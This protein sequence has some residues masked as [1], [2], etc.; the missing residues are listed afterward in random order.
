MA[1]NR[2]H[3]F[4]AGG[5][6]CPAPMTRA[7]L[8]TLRSTN[9]LKPE[10]HY[11]ITDHV[12]NRLVAGTT[13]TMH[14]VAP[15]ELSE[16]VEVNTTYDNEAWSGIYD[17]D[18]ALVLELTDNRNNT[19][20]GVNGTEV[21]NFDWG[22]A[23][24]SGCLVDNATWTV[25]YGSGGSVQR[26]RITNGSTLVTTGFVGSLLEPVITNAAVVNLTNA[27]GSWRYIEWRNS[28]F[29]NATG[30]TGANN[31]HTS[32]FDACTVNISGAS[33]AIMFRQ[34]EF[35]ASSFTLQGA[36]QVL[37]AAVN[38]M[39]H[40]FF[41]PATG[42]VLNAIRYSSDVA[43]SVSVTGSGATN[44]TDTK[45]DG[46]ISVVG[47]GTLTTNGLEIENFSSVVHN[48]AGPLSITRTRQQG[49]NSNIVTDTGS[50]TSVTI[51]D[52]NLLSNGNIRVVGGATG[53]ALNVSGCVV[54]GASYIYK[55]HTGALSVAQTNLYGQSGIDSQT[56]NRSYNFQRC[57]YSNVARASQTGTGA[58]TDTITDMTM[59]A[60][61]QFYL[62]ESGAANNILYSNISGITG[63]L[64]LDGA[65]GSQTI[66]RVKLRDANMTFT[67]CTVS[68]GVT[69]CTAED[70]G[71]ITFSNVTTAKSVQNFHVRN[72]GLAVVN[73]STGGGS[74]IGVDVT[75]FGQYVCSGAAAG[76]TYVTIQQGTV[77]HNGGNLTR[78]E[79]RQGGTLRTGS[80]NH[81][82]IVHATN[83]NRT[84]TA[85]NTARA[86]YMGLAAGAYTVGGILI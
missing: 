7:A 19:A 10:C 14:A 20:R 69:M 51:N 2:P 17:I 44:L 11:V 53:G 3:R 46:A 21:A 49:T 73:N 55:R 48:G 59:D 70:G 35:R 66:T 27:T 54:E 4:P 58:F 77:S 64:R 38:C 68:L 86:E 9:A 16:R 41:R 6:T 22:Y 8:L 32:E 34:S 65:T 60:R 30:Y 75:S 72:G 85:A 84:L 52:S 28:T 50:N 13:I 23:N 63:V 76:C 74:L 12:Q 79:K 43:G 42:G 82:S 56:G 40:S 24:Y 1:H 81:N 61:A 47:A 71:N 78:C 18:R 83:T 80:F 26:A 31:S 39:S 5:S 29:F 25:T 57:T 45:N 37:L 62:Q 15:N 33:G 36:A 67:G